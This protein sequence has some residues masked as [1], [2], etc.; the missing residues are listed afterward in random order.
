L[1]GKLAESGFAVITG[2][3]TGIMEA[4]NKGAFEAGGQSIGLNIELPQEQSINSYV[5]ESLSFNYF[6]SRK[7]ILSFASEAYVFFPGGFGTLDEFLEILTL[8]QTK[9][10]KKIPIILYG[11]DFWTPVTDL[12]EKT[13]LNSYDTISKEDLSLYIVVDT[14][15]EAYGEILRLVKC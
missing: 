7:V 5:T 8:V 13:L 1:G 2:G 9:K 11:R 6:F 4:G 3:S 12:F 14:V 15:D 10:I